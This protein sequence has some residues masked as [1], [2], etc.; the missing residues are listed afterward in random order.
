MYKACGTEKNNFVW[1]GAN[2]VYESGS[3]TVYTRGTSLIAAQDDTDL[4]YYL[5][6][7]HGDVVLLADEDGVITKTYAYDAFGVEKNADTADANSFR[8]CGEYFDAETDTYYLRARYYAP[9]LG[10]FTSEDPVQD[11]LNWYTYC[12][13]NPVLFVDPSGLY[14][15]GLR[16][17]AEEYGASVTW[18]AET[19][20][21]TVSYNG[22]SIHVKSTSDNNRDG[23]IYVDN[24]LLDLSFGWTESIPI[25]LAENTSKLP[26]YGAPNS[27]G[28]IYNPDG[29]IKQER[30]YGPNGEP[31][32]DRDYNHPG[33][34]E[35]PHDHVWSNG[36]RVKDHIP[37]PNAGRDNG[38]EIAIGIAS[39]GLGYTIH[40]GIKDI[41]LYSC[42]GI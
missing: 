31:E 1:D 20:Y 13:G 32:R 9:E 29:S 41:Q 2:L 19:G 36:K 40:M 6:N 27:V 5:F 8:Y 17:Y 25:E 18:N 10:R 28:R 23:H 42:F 35:F 4:S 34:M 11:G 22:Q 7:G 12:A 21:A 33:N 16:A 26:H 37:V 30:K 15:V 24:S 38:L 39:I 3:T 14:E